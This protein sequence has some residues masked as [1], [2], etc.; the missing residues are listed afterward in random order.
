MLDSWVPLSAAGVYRL[1]TWAFN[2]APVGAGVNQTTPSTRRQNAVKLTMVKVKK[3]RQLRFLEI[4][5]DR[6]AMPAAPS[7]APKSNP[8]SVV[9]VA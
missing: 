6:N 3:A 1:R 7:R 8:A 9:G 2:I 4:S 5:W